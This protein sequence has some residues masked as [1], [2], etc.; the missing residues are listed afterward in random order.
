MLLNRHSTDREFIVSRFGK[1]YLMSVKYLTAGSC[2]FIEL[3][4]LKGL[5][6][7]LDFQVTDV[8]AI[9]LLFWLF[10]EIK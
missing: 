4:L 5:Q 8:F 7:F 6:I 2:W 3:M 10:Q 9:V 1:V